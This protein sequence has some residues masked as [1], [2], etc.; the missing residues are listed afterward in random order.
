[1]IKNHQFFEVYKTAFA[2]S[3]N[4]IIV[5]DC[6]GRVQELNRAAGEILKVD[7]QECI[8][9]KIDK[10]LP[11]NEI[12]HAVREGQSLAGKRIEM[13]ELV[14]VF[15][16][17][18]I[19]VDDKTI[20]RVIIFQDI[21]F[22]ELLHT[23]VN[24]DYELTFTIDRN[25]LFNYAN[26]EACKEFRMTRDE[27]IGQEILK[28]FP[29]N[30]LLDVVKTGQPRLGEIGEIN[31]Q[32]APMIRV[33]LLRDGHI[34]GGMTKSIFQGMDK[35]R[36]FFST[37]MKQLEAEIKYYKAELKK[38]GSS[39]YTFE[40]YIGASD[41]VKKLIHEARIAA[42]TNS[43][44]LIRGE[45]G[46]GK[47][48]IAHAIHNASL[49]SFGDFIKVNCAA[50]P[51]N[52]L[53]SELFG[54]TDGS[55]TG[56]VRG[57]KT[58]KFELADGGTIFLDEIGDMPL[59]MQAKILRVLQEKEIEKIGSNKAVKVDVR[60]IAATN[61]NLE[62]MIEKGTFREDLYYR[63]N[64]INLYTPA[65][66]EHKEDLMLIV[67]GLIKRLSRVLN[68]NILGLTPKAVELISAY[69]W[70]GNVR[71]LENTLER[72]I[73]F[74]SGVWLR[75]EDFANL[76]NLTKNQLYGQTVR[77]LHEMVEEL[78]TAAI[79]KALNSTG[80][81]RNLAARL[82]KIHRS[83]LYRKIDKYKLN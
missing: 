14:L 56:A 48:I 39:S 71:Q 2:S 4:G 28:L 61:R 73:S 74:C 36:E 45:S 64:V 78:E 76:Y 37:R 30:K 7:V 32:Y 50:V 19:N 13:G 27:I 47:E 22:Q 51:E 38:E 66:R 23:I 69:D 3:T 21:S 83:V 1:M 80:N 25:G 15:N 70:P 81:N 68:K 42:S 9:E 18:P 57:G 46:T 77:P 75:P 20:G 72:A 49:R 60:V 54:Y 43:T 62:E 6:Q 79:R 40:H 52:L 65:L 10:I 8:G 44:V 26:D 58:G 11:N 82:L 63:L 41:I 55:F 35:A 33:P 29:K 59:T 17:S 67:E 16:V 53:E 31:G 34:V 5:T 12:L 24:N